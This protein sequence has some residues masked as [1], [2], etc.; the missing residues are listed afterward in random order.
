MRLA[1]QRRLCYSAPHG[2]GNVAEVMEEKYLTEMVTT[3]RRCIYIAVHLSV[4]TEDT[5]VLLLEISTKLRLANAGAK[6]NTQIILSVITIQVT[7]AMTFY[8]SLNATV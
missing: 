5:E 2:L 8:Q 4:K 3:L 6:R 1:F 7:N